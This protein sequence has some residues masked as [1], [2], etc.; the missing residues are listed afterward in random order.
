MNFNPRTSIAEATATTSTAEESEEFSGE[1]IETINTTIP[2]YQLIDQDENYI[3]EAS[4]QCD[5]LSPS[6]DIAC[7]LVEPERPAANGFL[8]VF[9]NDEPTA[10]PVH[11][12]I[13]FEKGAVS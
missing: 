11:E 12:F 6:V 4:I 1:P 10:I 13:P 2:E 3:C 9:Q 8:I 7:D 5:E